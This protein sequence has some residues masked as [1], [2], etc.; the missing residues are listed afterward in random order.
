MGRT[1]YLVAGE[2]APSMLG[3]QH[4][5]SYHNTAGEK[6]DHGDSFR[7]NK[8]QR[9]KA[10]VHPCYSE[11][12]SSGEWK[13]KSQFLL[14]FSAVSILHCIINLRINFLWPRVRH[15]VTNCPIC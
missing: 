8:V 13:I 5:C 10:C 7:V 4:S 12:S 2:I 15:T 3:Y 6:R 11:K 14:L 9:I 1:N